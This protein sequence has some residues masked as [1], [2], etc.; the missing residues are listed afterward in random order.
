MILA[1]EADQFRE[2]VAVL[3]ALAVN[4]KLTD[5]NAKFMSENTQLKDRLTQQTHQANEKTKAA[6]EEHK[7][8]ESEAGRADWMGLKFDDL[9]KFNAC[10]RKKAERALLLVGKDIL[11]GEDANNKMVSVCPPHAPP[12]QSPSHSMLSGQK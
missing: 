2:Q 9:R 6:K 8:A 12:W 1:R 3:K 10:L 7:R 5:S 4:A 11:V